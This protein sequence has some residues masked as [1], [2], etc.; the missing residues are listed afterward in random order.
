MKAMLRPLR[1]V[2]SNRKVA[3]PIA[4]ANSNNNSATKIRADDGCRETC[5]V[6]PVVCLHSESQTG[7]L[8]ANMSYRQHFDG[9]TER[10]SEPLLQFLFEHGQRPEFTCCFRC[11]KG[12]LAFWDNRGAKHAIIH[13]AGGF[14]RHGWRVQLAGHP[15]IPLTS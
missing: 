9:L 3:G 7:Y 2:H 6:H 11:R 5:L 4:A 15:P 8:L 14:L 13:D 10:V 12:S 1:A